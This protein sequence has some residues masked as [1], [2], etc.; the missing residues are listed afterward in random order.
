MPSPHRLFKNSS[1]DG[2][3]GAVYILWEPGGGGDLFPPGASLLKSVFFPAQISVYF[4]VQGQTVDTTSGLGL[5]HLYMHISVF[6]G[7]MCFF[8]TEKLQIKSA[9]KPAVKKDF[10]GSERSQTGRG[11]WQNRPW[12]LAGIWRRPQ[13]KVDTAS[14]VG[15]LHLYMHISVLKDFKSFFHRKAG[16]KIGRETAVKPAVKKDFAGSERSP[17]RPWF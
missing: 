6:K 17:T 13:F 12:R 1:S 10:A 3:G 9:V 8:F 15:L 4:T 2:A 16:S 7:F 5:L 11:F 14:G